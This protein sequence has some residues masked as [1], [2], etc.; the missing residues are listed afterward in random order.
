MDIFLFIKGFLFLNILCTL[1]L[2]LLF[3]IRS[4]DKISILPSLFMN[5]SKS[6][7]IQTS[8]KEK[9]IEQYL[10][11]H[12]ETY[13]SSVQR[14]NETRQFLSDMLKL[15]EQMI[16][17]PNEYFYGRGIVLTVR[18]FQLKFTKINL[19]MMELSN[20][21]LPVEVMRY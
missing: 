20:T 19:K 17:Y 7:A 10:K 12:F 16:S 8:F 18:I 21:R 1:L 13:A 4:G 5:L 15:H 9:L 2:I 6:Q 11:N 3:H 14:C